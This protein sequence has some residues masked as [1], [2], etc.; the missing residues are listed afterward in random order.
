MNVGS[1]ALGVI[2]GIGLL[3]GLLVYTGGM[4][5]DAACNEHLDGQNWSGEEATTDAEYGEVSIACTRGNETKTITVRAVEVSN[6]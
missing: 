3:T 6:S 5:Y 1:I 4:S 2:V